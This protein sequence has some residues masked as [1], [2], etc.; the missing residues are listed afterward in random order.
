MLKYNGNIS[1]QEWGLGSSYSNN[2]KYSYD[3]MNRLLSGIDN[4]NNSETIGGYDKVGNFI[5]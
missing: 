4:L 5:S 3:K 2:F 1:S